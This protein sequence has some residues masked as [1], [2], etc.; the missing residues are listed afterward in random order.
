MF[1]DA[2]L[3]QVL[4]LLE[5]VSAGRR[6]ALVAI[7]GASSSGKSTL[8]R[9]VAR[10][11]PDVAVVSLDHFRPVLTLG[12]LV[13]E[14]GRRAEAIALARERKIPQLGRTTILEALT[15]VLAET[16][17]LDNHVVEARH[18]LGD[19]IPAAQIRVRGR[20][21]AP[22][23]IPHRDEGVLYRITI[24]IEDA[25]RDRPDLDGLGLQRR[26]ATRLGGAS[27]NESETETGDGG[28]PHP[29][30]QPP[31]RSATPSHVLV[32]LCGPHSSRHENPFNPPT[33]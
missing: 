18:H 33:R 27:S 32:R 31:H 6:L 24:G 5:R 21:D 14:G 28:N 29:A 13:Q 3:G 22:F 9:A 23:A 20:R 19:G 11:W 16:P 8:A 1:S 2:Q 15:L 7:E 12:E 4:R 30:T 17:M 10:E 25:P 26:S